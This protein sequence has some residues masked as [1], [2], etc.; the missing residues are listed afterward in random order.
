MDNLRL[1]IN[2]SESIYLHTEW[3]QKTLAKKIR[4]GFTP[5][6]DYLAKCATMKEIIRKAAKYCMQYDGIKPTKAEREQAAKKHAE[7]IIECANYL[8]KNHEN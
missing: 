1:Y 4:K 3:L 5:S 6:V 2:N 7:Y 8:A